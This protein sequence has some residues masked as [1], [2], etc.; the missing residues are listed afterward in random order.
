MIFLFD[1]WQKRD[2]KQMFP[3]FQ[4]ILIDIELQEKFF[5]KTIHKFKA[6]DFEELEFHY[7][8]V[9]F[10]RTHP[11]ETF[12]RES[13]GTMMEIEIDEH[14]AW[15]ELLEVHNETIS[16][17]QAFERNEILM[18][19]SESRRKIAEQGQCIHEALFALNDDCLDALLE[20]DLMQ[21]AKKHRTEHC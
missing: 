17:L 1:L 5:R 19:E 12:I 20:S 14:N 13:E 10:A 16:R 8:R 11:V 7:K 15:H 21:L 3:R 18:D 4:R 9:T 2:F 6:S